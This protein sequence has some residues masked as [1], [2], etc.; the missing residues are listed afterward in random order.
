MPKQE[1]GKKSK[2]TEKA[3]GNAK[4]ESKEEKEEVI[5]FQ[6]YFAV[7]N[8]VQETGVLSLDIV[9]GLGDGQ[10]KVGG[11]EKGDL[12][13]FSSESGLG[14]STTC[15]QILKN[16]ILDNEKCAFLDIERAVKERT[17]QGFGIL[18]KVGY[19][20][21]DPFLLIAPSTFREVEEV[22]DAIFKYEPRYDLVFIDSVR[23][24]LA[25]DAT[26]KSVEDIQVGGTSQL[27]TAFLEKYKAWL[28]MTGITMILVNQMRT[29]MK[30]IQKGFK[31]T[32]LVS[33]DSAGPKAM[34]FYPD[35]RIRMQGGS[36][37]SREELTVEGKRK[38]PYGNMAKVWTEKHR[39]NRPKIKVE[40]PIIYGKGISSVLTLRNILKLNRVI[41][42][43]SGGHFS[44]NLDDSDEVKLHGEKELAHYVMKNY[45][46]LKLYA[47]RRGM[48]ELTQAL[49]V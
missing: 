16:K 27:A 20:L 12:I 45:E 4:S 36:P 6:K 35:I 1:K 10:T 7:G 21:G 42:G 49:E 46:Q 11:Y 43:G 3:K 2:K 47:L 17:L 28:R 22:L 13:E 15:L 24:V 8:P 48:L 19:K 34:T 9:L 38:V 29:K 41:S 40:M 26:E 39:G 18:D 31:K 33:E 30:T 37:L 32:L 5:S 23:A 14:K 44:V 25:S